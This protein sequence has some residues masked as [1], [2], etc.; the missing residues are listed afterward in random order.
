MHR[1]IISICQK[2]IVQKKNRNLILLQNFFEKIINFQNSYK[3]V[4]VLKNNEFP[5]SLQLDCTTAAAGP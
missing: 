4:H 3:M 5:A 1:L 2:K